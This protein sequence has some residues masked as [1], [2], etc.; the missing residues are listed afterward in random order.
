MNSIV[1]P[2]R[3]TTQIF[4][5]RAHKVHGEM[6][7]YSLV[8]YIDNRTKVRI[9]CRKCDRVFEQTPHAHW[10]GHK[11]NLCHNATSNSA[12]ANNKRRVTFEHIK[13]QSALIHGDQFEYHN[14]I[15]LGARRRSRIKLTCKK[16]KTTFE[17]RV[18]KHLGGSG[19]RACASRAKTGG[20][21]TIS[22]D[23]FKYRA[24]LKHAD[25]YDYSEVEFLFV[26]KEK[27]KITCRQCNHAFWQ[28]AIGHMNG[29]GCRPC[30]MRGRM[31]RPTIDLQEFTTR[32]KIQHGD[33]Y[34]YSLVEFKLVS[35]KVTII[36]PEHGEFQTVARWHMDG[37]GCVLCGIIKQST[38]NRL[39]TDEFI[40][41]A[42]EKHGDRYD[43]SQTKYVSQKDQVQIICRTHGSFFVS[44][45]NHQNGAG[46]Q[47]CS[48][49]SSSGENAVEKFLSD[50]GVEHER[51]KGFPGLIGKGHPYWFDFYLPEINTCIE[52]NGI[53][54]YEPVEF[55]GGQKAL[56]E[57]IRRDQEKRQ[58]CQTNGVR[59]IEIPYTVK[60]VDGFLR[61]ALCK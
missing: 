14:L 56:N 2:R 34:D 24:A 26:S 13:K 16:C 57:T 42:R 50:V 20:R 4:I 41:H 40:G 39:T 18:E 36:C 58:W 46:C 30:K 19:C 9:I 60:D 5:E 61:E 10:S 21:P 59:L 38:N 55:F 23:E 52:Y 35:D 53:Q 1:N 51:E 49:C 37:Y 47:S 15:D 28:S 43:Y 6:F 31:G 48:A 8:E 45:N 25:K 11:C 27:V 44:A 22:L 3:L 17:Q 33:K 12:A 29:R 7:D 54:H 32:S